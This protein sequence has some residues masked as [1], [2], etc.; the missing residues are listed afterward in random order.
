MIDPVLVAVGNLSDVAA[1]A[2]LIE[3]AIGALT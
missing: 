2:E 1:L 3:T